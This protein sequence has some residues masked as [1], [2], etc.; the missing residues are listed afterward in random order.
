MVDDIRYYG[1]GNFYQVGQGTTNMYQPWGT[2][3]PDNKGNGV[4]SRYP[5]ESCTEIRMGNMATLG[6]NQVGGLNDRNCRDVNYVMCVLDGGWRCE[7]CK[8]GAA[9]AAPGAVNSPQRLHA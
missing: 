7:G 4:Q 3:Q 1:S 9:G 5:H 2:S 8:G 6:G